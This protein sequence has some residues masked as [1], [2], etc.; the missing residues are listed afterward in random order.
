MQANVMLVIR[1]DSDHILKDNFVNA[2][3]LSLSP[4]E[5]DQTFYKTS[6]CQQGNFG[7]NLGLL[8]GII[9]LSIKEII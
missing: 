2:K 7:G 4:L 1:F 8:L 9:V 3:C 5:Y 6:N